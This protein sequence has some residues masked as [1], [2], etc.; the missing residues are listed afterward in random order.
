[1]PSRVRSR[2][3]QA[4]V[5]RVAHSFR[6]SLSSPLSQANNFLWPFQLSSPLGGLKKKGKHFT[7]DGDYGNREEAINQLIRRMN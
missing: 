2:A 6:F 7:E 3:C 5:D 1:M 4:F